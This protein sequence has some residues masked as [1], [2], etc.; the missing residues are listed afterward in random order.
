MRAP[1]PVSPK[2][3][4][5]VESLRSRSRCALSL[6]ET[7]SAL[8]PHGCS[9]LACPV[10]SGQKRVKVV[11]PKLAQAGSGGLANVPGLGAPAALSWVRRRRCH[12]DVLEPA[13]RLSSLPS[14]HGEPCQPLHGGQV[15][16]EDILRALPGIRSRSRGWWSEGW[17]D[18]GTRPGPGRAAPGAGSDGS[19]S[20]GSSRR[21]R[22]SR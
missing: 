22:S 14:T 21:S 6:P 3:L 8:R 1:N 20:G 13:S 7:Q 11:C 19:A 10:R 15:A 17:A 2:L 18:P 5:L 9:D 4:A 16:R 12:G